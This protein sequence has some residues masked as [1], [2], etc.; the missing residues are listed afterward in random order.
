[1]ESSKLRLMGLSCEDLGPPNSSDLRLMDPN[2]EDLR[3]PKSSG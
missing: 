3:G 2:S 1:M